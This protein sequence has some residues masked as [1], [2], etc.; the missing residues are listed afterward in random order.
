MWG[1]L[2]ATNTTSC[3]LES[4]TLID[5]ID[6]DGAPNTPATLDIND[7][8]SESLKDEEGP[9]DDATLTSSTIKHWQEPL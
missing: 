6:V 2:P 9:Q 5:D 4:S 3:G 1:G 7:D 8:E